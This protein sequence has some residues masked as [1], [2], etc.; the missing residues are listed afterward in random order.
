MSKSIDDEIISYFRCTYHPSAVLFTSPKFKIH[1]L[2]NPLAR[3]RLFE[4]IFLIVSVIS[5]RFRYAL[6][7]STY[8]Y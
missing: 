1:I 5:V 4:N 3:E 7:E 6:Y 8:E 2:N